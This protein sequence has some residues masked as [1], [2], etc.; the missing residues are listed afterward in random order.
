V[1]QRPVPHQQVA[2]LELRLDHRELGPVDPRPDG[3]AIR[4][5][6]KLPPVKFPEQSWCALETTAFRLGVRQRDDALDSLRQHAQRG[7]DVPVELNIKTSLG[8]R[9]ERAIAVLDVGRVQVEP[10]QAHPQFLAVPYIDERIVNTLRLAA[11]P[12][13]LVVV[14]LHEAVDEQLAVQI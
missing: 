8:R 14:R 11:V 10:V 13:E 7:V 6:R 1:R 3:I 5:L 12:Q 9:D 2:R 4:W